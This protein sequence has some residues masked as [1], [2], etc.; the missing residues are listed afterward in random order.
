MKWVL[1]V[2]LG[3]AAL[4]A[5]MAIVG[6]RLPREH[7]ASRTLRVPRPPAD[8][9]PVVTRIAGAA[10]VPVDVVESQAPYRLVTRVKPSEKQFGGTWTIAIAPDAQASTLTITEDGWVASP[11]FR[12]MS[13]YVIGHH[14]T[15][16][17]LLKN[18][19]KEL[20]APAELSGV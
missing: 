12:F 20:N 15:M 4:V 1:I 6:A 19:A 17:S 3:L 18:V 11:V 5:M 2:L 10:S 14:A 16:D 9:W 8:V 13:R 7:R